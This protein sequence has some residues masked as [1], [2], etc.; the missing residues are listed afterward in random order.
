MPL[1]AGGAKGLGKG[2]ER[3]ECVTAPGWGVVTL[4]IPSPVLSNDGTGGNWT[5]KSGVFVFANV[6]LAAE[7]RTGVVAGDEASVI[8][9]S[10]DAGNK[11]GSSES[12]RLIAGT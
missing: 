6:S 4:W 1:T 12:D 2:F 10:P 11:G 5:L 8:E 7:P 3:G 9:T